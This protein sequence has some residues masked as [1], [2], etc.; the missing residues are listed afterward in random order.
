MKRFLLLACMCFTLQASAYDLYTHL[1]IAQQVLN[2]IMKKGQ[3]EINGR[4]YRLDTRVLTA[5]KEHPSCFR[6]GTLGPDIFPDPVVGQ[7][8]AHPGVPGGW[9]TDDWIA[10][11]LREARSGKE[12]ALAYG[13][14]CHAAMDMFAHTY[15]NSYAGDIF[16]LLD[17]ELDVELRHFL[18]EKYIGLSL[19]QLHDANGNLVTI[20]GSLIDAPRKFLSRAFILHNGLTGQYSKKEV[21]A[22]HLIAMNAVYVGVNKARK[23]TQDIVGL[24]ATEYG[25]LL[26]R[27]QTMALEL[28]KQIGFTKQMELNFKA[29]ALALELKREANKMLT[30]KIEL[31]KKMIEEAIAVIA[32]AQDLISKKNDALKALNDLDHKQASEL[33]EKKKELISQ[34]AKLGSIDKMIFKTVSKRVKKLLGPLSFIWETITET[35]SK[36]N[37]AW[38][39]QEK[40]VNELNNVISKLEQGVV[41]AKRDIINT[42]IDIQAN[43]EKVQNETARKAASEANRLKYEAE[44]KIIQTELK[45]AET[46]YNEAKA[47]YDKAVA[48]K[49]NL[50]SAYKD[51]LERIMGKVVGLV[52]RYNLINLYLSNWIGDIEKGSEAYVEAGEQ[53]AKSVLNGTGNGFSVY[54]DWWKCWKP[55]FTGVPSE[56]PGGICALENFYG[57]INSE[58]DK[59]IEDMGAF[60]WLVAPQ[61]KLEAEVK[62]ELKPLMDKALTD[63]ST[64]LLGERFTQF[65]NL[66]SQREAFSIQRLQEVFG[67]D[68]SDKHLLV[69]PSVLPLVQEELGMVGG[70]T[71]LDPA[72]FNAFHNSI[73]LSKLTVLPTVSLNQL[74]RDYCGNART[75]YGKVLYEP[76]ADESKF[77][78]LL[79][80]VSSIDGSYQWMNTSLPMP[81]QTGPDDVWQRGERKYGYSHCDNETYGFRFWVD[82][83]SREKIFPVIFRG[84]LTKALNSYASLNPANTAF[85]ACEDVPF[86]ESEDHKCRQREKDKRCG[87]STLRRFFR[88]LF[89]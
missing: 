47:A 21:S 25:K 60:G 3:M 16:S 77:S 37:P 74:H 75:T 40:V 58:I 38:I 36:V 87:E 6:I 7:I 54:V 11:V 1:W 49:E 50:E 9:K 39:V 8:S 51:F 14:A 2:D 4:T 67:Q 13:Y 78:L 46:T 10:H 81:R 71:Q 66:V 48:L 42:G 55:V 43:V 15:V 56:V 17:G 44:L 89:D 79:K 24:V 12:I 26:I 30:E 80:A 22:Y 32:A 18:L 86:P 45:V 84:P 27:K 72:A 57:K 70:R 82:K 85:E 61:K 83:K 88:R 64:I 34:A 20:N 29:A 35:V 19:P 69:I 73:V 52:K 31:E 68:Q 76:A 59:I 41:N 33:I 23:T 53:F 62:Q 65:F 5:L 63:V 28:E